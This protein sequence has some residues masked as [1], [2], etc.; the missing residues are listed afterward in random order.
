MRKAIWIIFYNSR[1]KIS[2]YVINRANHSSRSGVVHTTCWFMK[3]VFVW[4]RRKSSKKSSE[5]VK[6]L[7]YNLVHGRCA[8]ITKQLDIECLAWEKKEKEKRHK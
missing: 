6:V 5:M 7:T 1:M 2:N 3:T 4:S 8:A